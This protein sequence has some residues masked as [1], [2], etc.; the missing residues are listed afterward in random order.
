M[1]DLKKVLDSWKP[2]ITEHK[3]I[4]GELYAVQPFMF[5]YGV[6]LKLEM[7]MYLGR[8]CFDS[9]VCAKAFFDQYDGSQMPVVGV[10]GCTAIKCP[11]LEETLQY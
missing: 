5:T 10:D 3:I 4:D 1:T 2:Y 6:L 9:L 8:Y 11:D 7:N